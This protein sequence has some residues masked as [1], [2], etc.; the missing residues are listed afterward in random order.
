MWPHQQAPSML[1][2]EEVGHWAIIGSHVIVVR[3]IPL[4][5]TED[6]LPKREKRGNFTNTFQGRY[7]N[8][9]SGCKGENE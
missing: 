4:I 6:R 7:I 2:I 8:V 3:T 1:F 5:V 9:E